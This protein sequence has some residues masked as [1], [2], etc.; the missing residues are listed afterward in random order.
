MIPILIYAHRTARGLAAEN[1]LAG[2]NTCIEL[3]VDYID[4]DV[5]LTKDHILV[6]THDITL[7]PD[8]TRD[9]KGEY[10]KTKIPIYSLTFEQLKRYNVGK[11]DPKSKYATYFPDQVTSEHAT[12]PSLQEAL[13]YVK[14]Q[15]P[16]RI[17]FQI[18]LKTECPDTPPPK[19]FAKIVH[20][21]LLESDVIDR[22]EVQAFDFNYLAALPP[23]TQTSYVT[24]G[25]ISLTNQVT[26]WTPFEMDVTEATIRQAQAK[27]IKVVP[28]GYPEKEGTEFN[29]KQI[30][31]LIEWGVDGIITDRP[32]KLK[33]TL[34]THN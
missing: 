30:L 31:K 4:F 25:V 19:V 1:T 10:I 18:E 6:V 9:E 13:R 3:G 15:A 32:D 11:I 33:Q 24:E 22:C 34:L 16:Y 23:E 5:A 29:E 17:K 8:I 14:E 20:Q 28:W 27:G 12:I 7:N 26:C 2:C 21:T